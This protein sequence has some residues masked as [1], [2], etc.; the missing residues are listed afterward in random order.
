MHAHTLPLLQCEAVL[1]ARIATSYLGALPLNTGLGKEI[2]SEDFKRFAELNHLILA[3]SGWVGDGIAE[4]IIVDQSTWY[5]P[6][7]LA[8]FTGIYKPR[9]ANASSTYSIDIV[10]FGSVFDLRAQVLDLVTSTTTTTSSFST[11]GLGTQYVTLTITTTNLS[12]L[13]RLSP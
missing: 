12:S 1:P 13:H 3:Q 6:A 4:N 8:R 11:S 2:D 9:R 5:T 10:A 7:R